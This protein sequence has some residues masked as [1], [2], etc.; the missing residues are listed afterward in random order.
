MRYF[1]RKSLQNGKKLI[2]PTPMT[3]EDEALGVSED[4]MITVSSM[5]TQDSHL[6][7][8]VSGFREACR[9]G[10]AHPV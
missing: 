9:R 10:R 1:D 5:T 7:E 2:L 6:S 8:N 3:P 4:D